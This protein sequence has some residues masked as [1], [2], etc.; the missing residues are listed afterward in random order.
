M[1]VFLPTNLCSSAQSADRSS[2]ALRL[3]L[4]CIREPNPAREQAEARSPPDA[5][6]RSTKRGAAQLE[7]VAHSRQAH[8]AGESRALPSAPPRLPLSTARE[9]PRRPSA[10]FG[11]RNAEFILRFRTPH[12]AF[13]AQIRL[14]RHSPAQ[15]PPGH[16][17]S[18]LFLA[19]PS[20]LQELHD[21]DEPTRLVARQAQRQRR[22]RPTPSTRLAQTRLANACCVGMRNRTSGKAQPPA[23][24]TRSNSYE[25]I[26]RIPTTEAQRRR[27][28][29]GLTG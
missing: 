12:S 2:A 29:T 19:S 16:L 1:A 8:H 23:Q 22:S 25:V 9:N 14:P 5:W 15:T 6:Q 7:Y 17:C 28:S 11:T 18:R 26:R 3:P 20:R 10:E 24:A 21:P 13:R 4:I 27:G